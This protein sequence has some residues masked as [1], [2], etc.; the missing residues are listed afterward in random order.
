M[1]RLHWQPKEYTY[2]PRAAVSRADGIFPQSTSLSVLSFL[3]P[4][5]SFFTPLCRFGSDSTPAEV[6]GESPADFIWLCI[7]FPVISPPFSNAQAQI[8]ALTSQQ[9]G[10]CPCII[11]LLVSHTLPRSSAEQWWGKLRGIETARVSSWKENLWKTFG[12]DHSE[13][14]SLSFSSVNQNETRNIILS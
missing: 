14:F 8:P 1:L 5:C 4:H 2:F 9:L 6:N 7:L 12:L 11:S 3:M 10:S 13:M